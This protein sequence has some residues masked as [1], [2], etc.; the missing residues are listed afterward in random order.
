MGF[1]NYAIFKNNDEGEIDIIKES[2]FRRIFMNGDSFRNLYESVLKEK[3]EGEIK[4]FNVDNVLEFNGIRGDV[5]FQKESGQ[6]VMFIQID[7]P[8]IENLALELFIYS[9]KL[10]E[11]YLEDTGKSN[12]FYNGIEVDIDAPILIPV[13]IGS[14]PLEKTTYS[15][16]SHFSEISD[17]SLQVQFEVIDINYSKL[18]EEQIERNDDLVG[19]SYLMDRI[20]YHHDSKNLDIEETLNSAIDDCKA[21]QYLEKYLNSNEFVISAL[22]YLNE[23][24][25]K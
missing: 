23:I 11:M 12:K 1:E 16:S 17:S 5:I 2:I 6:L 24:F 8:Y 21:K 18:L 25:N 22:I 14:E 9:S 13:Y 4:Y 19:Y 15:L 20:F 3:L 10:L 7:K